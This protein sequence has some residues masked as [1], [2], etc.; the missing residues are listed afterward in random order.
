MPMPG[1]DGSDGVHQPSERQA[2][3]RELEGL[4][5]AEQTRI[6]LNLVVEQA[7]HVLRRVRPDEEPA[8]DPVLPFKELG[9]DSLALVEVH[10]RL[11][12]ATGLAL[13]VTVAFDHPT[14]E[15]LAGRLRAELLGEQDGVAELPSGASRESRDGDDEPI[16]VVGIGCQLPGGIDSPEAL[17]QAVTEGRTVVGPFPAD[18]G[19][20]LDRLFDSD[21]DD[22]GHS[23]ARTG[24]FLDRAAEFDADFFGISPRE[25]LAMEPQQRLLLE[26]SWEALERAGIAPT[27]LRG[28]RTGVFVGAGAHEYGRRSHEPADGLDGYLLTGTSLSIASGRIAYVLGLEGPA[29]T[30]DTACSGSLVALH[31]AVQSLHRG[32][33]RLALAGGATLMGSPA[34]FT[35]FSRQRGLAPDGLI[36]AFAAGADGTAFGEGV[37]VL[38]LE[39][40]SDAQRAGHR[41]LGVIRGTGLNQDGASNGLTAPS[42]AAQRRL[43]RETLAT[44]GLTAADV[45]AVEAHG[46]GTTLGDPVEAQALLATY[47]QERP[48]DR[49]LRLGSVKSNVGHTQ[50]AGGAVGIIKMLMAMRHEV[51]PR[52]LH[53]DAP[54]PN[55]DWSAGHIE[56]LTEEQPWP[57]GERPRRAGVSAF[58]V[59]G[60]NAHVIVEE[61]PASAEAPGVV[62]EVP[63][64]GDAPG[65][66]QPAVAVP[67]ASR[68]TPVVVTAKN[69]AALRAQARRLLE[70]TEERP[71]VTA[72]DLGHALTTTRALLGRR[73]VVVAGDRATLLD[74]LR[75]VADGGTGPAV[76]HGTASG[77]RLAHLFTGQGSQR[78]GM[79]AQLHAAH[80]VFR[81]ALEDAIGHLDVQLERSLWDV[82]FAEPDSAE[83]RLLDQTVYA[84]SALFAVETA[85]FRLLESWGLRPDFLCGHSIGELTAAHAAGVLSL[86]D[87]ATLVAARGR[88]MQELPPGGAMLAVQATEEETRPL[89]T[90]EVGIAAVNGPRS[91]VVSGTEDAVEALRRHFAQLG[92]R[93][94]RLRVSHA[95]HS[96]LMEPMLDEFQRI[97][98]ILTYHRPRI[99]VVS[100]LTGRPAR[101]EELCDPEYWVRHVREAVRFHDGVRWLADNGVTTFLE[102]GP[103][104]VLTA[105]AQDALDEHPTTPA[106][107]AAL[108][109][110]RDE[111]RQ[112]LSALALAHARGAHVDWAAHFADRT[113]RPVDLPTYAFQRRRF[114]LTPPL[115]QNQ[116]G[117]LGQTAADHPL[118]GAVVPLAGSDSLVLTGTL[119]LHGHPW[120][121]DHVIAGTTVLPG[122]AFVELAVAAGDR[123]GAPRVAELTLETPLVLP[124]EGGVALQLAVGEADSTGSR[125]IACYSR[126]QDAPADTPWERHASGLLAPGTAVPSEPGALGLTEWPPPGAEPVGTTDLYDTLARHGYG[127]GPAFQGVRHVWRRDGEVFAEVALEQEAAADAQ[128]FGLHPAL[129]DAALHAAEL[130]SDE[131]L[132]EDTR[133]PFSWSGMELHS[134]GADSLRVRVTTTG[135]DELSVAIADGTG[136]PVALVESLV[137]RPVSVG[138]LEAAR[139]AS[140][141]GA[142]VYALRWEPLA[143]GAGAGAGAGAV[144]L[145]AWEERASGGGMPPVVLWDA[146]SVRVPETAGVPE[147][148]RALTGGVLGAVQEWLGDVAAGESA[149][150]V[151]TRGASSG[152][153]PAMG[154]VPGLVRAVQA[155]HPGR[156]LLVDADGAASAG[157]IA[158][159]V[160]LAL[161]ADEPEVG[162]RE[163]AVCV[164]R[165]AAESGTEEL[166]FAPA[167]TVLV[168]GGTGALGGYVT[169]HL[170]ERYGVRRLLLTSRRGPQAPGAAELCA[171]L[172]ALG[173]EVSVVAADVSDAEAVAGL[174][175]TV[176]DEHPLTAVVHTAGV[177]EDGLVDR[178][179]PEQ[180]DRVLAAKADAAWHLHEQTAGLGLDAF[181]L[182]SSASG[183]LDGAGQGNYAAANTFLD[184]LAV[185]RRDLGLP[186][187]SLAWGLW[188]GGS[189]MGGDLDEAALRR[190]RRIGLVGLTPQDNLGLLDRALACAAP[191]VAPLRIDTQALRTGDDEIPAVLRGLVRRPV[192]RRAVAGG[193]A[194]AGAGGAGSGTASVAQRLAGLDE[195]ARTEALLDLVRTQAADI[196]GHSGPE[197]VDPGRAFNDLG[198]DSLAAV[199][200][201]NRLSSAAGLRLTAT[202][203]FDYPTPTDLARHLA[204]AAQEQRPLPAR[205]A[206]APGIADADDPVVIV[207]MACRYPGDVTSPEDLWRLVAD[208]RDVV[209]AFP[210]DRGW[211]RDLYDPEPGKP[212]KSSTKEGGFLYDAA[213]FDPEFFGIS[214]REAQAMDPQQRLLLEVSWETLERAGIDPTT[215]RGSDTGMFAGVMYHDW[216]LRSGPLPEDIAAYHGNGSLASLVSG[217]VAYVLG[218]E[219]PAV[220][221]DTACSS[222]LVALHWAMQALR[223]GECSLALAGGVTVMSTPDTFIDMNRQRGLASDGRCKSF[224]AGADGTGW[225][226]GVGLL[227][228]ERLSDARRNGH[229]V[230]AVVRGSAVNQDGASNG[231]TAPNGPSQQRVIRAALANAGLSAAD[232]D[233]VE[234]HGTGT[235]LGDPIEAQALLATYG[236]ERPSG[237]RPLWLGSLKSN[238][239]HTQAAAGV[240]GVIKMVT[241]L[242]HGL[243]PRSLHSEQP[244][245]QVDWESGAVRLLDHAVEWPG[246]GAP[247]R[248]GVSS[249]GISGTNAHVI[250]E[251][252]PVEEPVDVVESGPGG[253]LPVVVSAK[254][255]AAL[256]DQALRLREFVAGGESVRLV[257]AAYSL[258]VSR[259]ALEHRAVVLASDTEELV[260]GLEAL[261]AGQTGPQVLRGRVSS[262]GRLAFTFSGQ[263]AQRAGMGAQLAGRFREFRKA[264]KEVCALLEEPVGRLLLGGDAAASDG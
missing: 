239:G 161:A 237:E 66:E 35:E 55:V 135:P 121:A 102:L 160:G 145:V 177:I 13:P 47:G 82:L 73:A 91:V 149:L 129:L 248:A 144:E 141:S 137:S 182:Y 187:L 96:P 46:T 29:L 202:L 113:P 34:V 43:I 22:S 181:I 109:R 138:R 69:E 185:H 249:F 186:A 221:V 230:L 94:T 194:F 178:M 167:G 125:T 219:G 19:W 114:W 198:F 9:L 210:A 222:S 52:T 92:R 107:V 110:D 250:V 216:G 156:V 259:A 10:A 2:L 98:Q 42:G 260:A 4:P 195:A 142:G 118:L 255:A 241:A 64:V 86:E 235:T 157:G 31:L 103:D 162:L 115:P 171:E 191:A 71:D 117:D 184:A 79:G 233:A 254:S 83:A 122:T 78:L 111:E 101:P 193:S 62:D 116:A 205:P 229:R 131:P 14:P 87:A 56:L 192:R 38:V 28:S 163:G 90:G 136:A 72:T 17:W 65:A 37:A 246:N 169:R 208:G 39:R 226:E 261:A 25:A 45:D 26:T 128:R 41:V 264:L 224:G 27:A 214:P 140:S 252:A 108:R 95:F 197:E 154:A 18:R 61:P 6:L 32:E 89:L 8:P 58:G 174:L 158:E 196:L 54:S 74:G 150:V 48:E 70:F 105:L 133:V 97:A 134:A 5:A 88:L 143:S 180:L 49:P 151:L 211:P 251:E 262:G 253:V 190:A 124:A 33:C 50:A 77:G 258:A 225:S 104:P 173:A 176:Q 84:Q 212:G 217:R 130:A 175:A 172:E 155:E 146:G 80:P 204:S 238:M 236:Q 11:N 232:V 188:T 242:Q 170:V 234:G 179:T 244:S 68:L 223:S 245:P 127:Y 119:S 60:T 81:R 12:A 20:D 30:V 227:L 183:F 228:L 164:P 257:D 168:T 59:S 213:G 76:L 126:P 15:L 23:I 147:R 218:L 203:T 220:T 40:L 112:A 189:G 199:E 256:P 139:R 215:L 132:P 75:A 166:S 3:T 99:P 207:G 159:A 57:R 24:G 209:S 16:A 53:V 100:N 243:L 165:L 200:L 148:V 231:L 36:K 123:T 263:G 1:R 85:L 51:L 63:V 153:D 67:D 21:P 206:A 93:T 240:G 106:F 152:A 44:A 7:R 247:R 201:R 120:L